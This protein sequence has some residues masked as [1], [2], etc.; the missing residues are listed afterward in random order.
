MRGER[1]A[2]V[3]V[4]ALAALGLAACGGSGSSGAASVGEG[5]A[6]KVEKVHGRQRVVL[7]AIAAR[8]IGLRTSTVRPGSAGSSAAVPYSAVLYTAKG[9]TFTYVEVAPHAYTRAP[10]QIQRISTREAFLSSGPRPG[11]AVVTVG[12]QELHGTETGI[13]EPE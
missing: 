10:V 2:A 12:A 5:T 13:Q 11:A 7:S 6:A 8:R 1:P 4:T 9:R 3:A